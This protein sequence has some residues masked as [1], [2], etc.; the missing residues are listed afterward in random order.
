MALV[1]GDYQRGLWIIV[2]V[3]TLIMGIG[4]TLLLLAFRAFG[5]VKKGEIRHVVLVVVTI[6]FVMLSSAGLFIWSLLHNG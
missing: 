2:I 1:E 5:K 3:G 6:I 4:G